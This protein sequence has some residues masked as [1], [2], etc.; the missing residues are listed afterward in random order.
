MKRPTAFKHTLVDAAFSIAQPK[1]DF[2]LLILLSLSY[3]DALVL[4]FCCILSFFLCISNVSQFKDLQTPFLL[5]VS[6]ELCS[7]FLFRSPTPFH[8]RIFLPLVWVIP[9]LAHGSVHYFCALVEPHLF[10]PLTVL[11]VVAKIIIIITIILS[12]FRLCPVKHNCPY[13]CVVT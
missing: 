8:S 11:S 1:Q 6:W 5:H 2:T 9:C 12:H 4:W 3:Q 7:H 13:L 10:H